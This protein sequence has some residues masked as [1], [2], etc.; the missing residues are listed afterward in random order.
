MRVQRGEAWQG[1]PEIVRFTTRDLDA[2]DFETRARSRRVPVALLTLFIIFLTMGFDLESDWF[3]GQNG[4]A[5]YRYSQRLLYDG[6][7]AE[8]RF[9][10][11]LDEVERAHLV[12]VNEKK[13]NAT[14]STA[15]GVPPPFE[16]DLQVNPGT[17]G[18]VGDPRE[19]SGGAIYPQR[20]GGEPAI[21]AGG[22]SF[23]TLD[24]AKSY[25]GKWCL[26]TINKGT[27]LYPNVF[28]SDC[29]ALAMKLTTGSGRREN[30]TLTYATVVLQ[31][32]D[33]SGELSLKMHGEFKTH[34]NYVVL[35]GSM[36]DMFMK[37]KPS[38]DGNSKAGRQPPYSA[39]KISSSYQF[40]DTL[41]RQEM[42]RNSSTLASVGFY[43][44]LED[45]LEVDEEDLNL[46]FLDGVMHSE[47]CGW[48]LH[49][50]ATSINMDKTISK[51]TNYCFMMVSIAILQLV[52]L[53]H[54]VRQ[55]ANPGVSLL[56]LGQQAIIDAYLCL[57]H[58]TAG[59]VADDMFSALATAAFCEFVVFSM[60]EM[61]YLIACSHSRLGNQSNWFEAQ[62][63]IGTIYGRFYGVL[64]SGII[65]VY[66]FKDHYLFL[67]FLVYS[68]WIPQIL[69]NAIHAYRR[70]LKPFFIV[71][72]SVCRLILPLYFFGY[73]NNFLKVPYSPKMCFSLTFYVGAQVGLLLLQYYKG[74]R[75]F[76]P[77]MFLPEQY[78]YHRKLNTSQ[79]SELCTKIQEEGGLDCV[80]CMS[81][82]DF[83]D[84]K[85]RMVTPCNHFFHKECLERWL[86]VKMECPTCRRK[87]PPAE[88]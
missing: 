17:F 29:G 31:N 44:S 49:M 22:G 88:Y 48:R 27:E 78:D 6:S 51:V 42:D 2:M 74:S 60:F 14:G 87:L 12:R 4:S 40:S 8:K 16:T 73:P 28:T 25:R 57:I 67:T 18:V 26:E 54:Q 32:K 63:D 9:N 35:L 80:I 77:K 7:S 70:P 15:D 86:K 34:R 21:G 11:K 85:N 83:K 66:E 65:L 10:D 43:D 36:R 53:V 68:F 56:S 62:A 47:N 61:R 71:G 79:S 24:I 3:A 37:N 13:E 45:G 76:I 58:L 72:M 23:E 75:C 39:C 1:R 59:I 5:R 64:L 82:V 30:S 33:R 38:R 50:N 41:P 46:L 69:R 19:A 81:S 52:C 20:E 55:V 84:P